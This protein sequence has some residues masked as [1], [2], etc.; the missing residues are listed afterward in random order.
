MTIGR[1][2]KDPDKIIYKGPCNYCHNPIEA[3]KNYT[4]NAKN[5]VLHHCPS[6]KGFQV[7]ITEQDQFYCYFNGRLVKVKFVKQENKN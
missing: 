3:T 5:K 2:I 6:Y 4:Y 1:A 7:Q